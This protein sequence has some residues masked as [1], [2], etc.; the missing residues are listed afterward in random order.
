MDAIRWWRSPRQSDGRALVD[1]DA[2]SAQI[3][4]D[5]ASALGRGRNCLMLTRRVAHLNVLADL[6][7]S[8][9]HTALVLQ[10]GMPVTERRPP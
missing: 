4:D 5:V 10:G 9:G 1:D 8:R 7:A 6:L 3:V 2:R